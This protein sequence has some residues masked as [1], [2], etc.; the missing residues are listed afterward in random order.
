MADIVEKSSI[1]KTFLMTKCLGNNKFPWNNFRNLR[2][3]QTISF[4]C[5]VHVL[6]FV[7]RGFVRYRYTII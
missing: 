1:M 4:M 2:V 7:E 5:Y 6:C 3:K